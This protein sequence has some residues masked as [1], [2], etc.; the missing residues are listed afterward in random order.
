M[1]SRNANKSFA[2]KGSLKI[3]VQE[4]NSNTELGK[5][6][7]SLCWAEGKVVCEEVLWIW[8]YKKQLAHN[9]FTFFFNNTHRA[10]TPCGFLNRW[11][12]R[13]SFVIFF[14]SYFELN[15]SQHPQTRWLWWSYGSAMS[16]N[17][18]LGGAAPL[19]QAQESSLLLMQAKCWAC[20]P[21]TV[22]SITQS[23]HRHS[24]G[25]LMA[26]GTDVQRVIWR[27][28]TNRKNWDSQRKKWNQSLLAATDGTVPCNHSP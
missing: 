1:W 13:Q 23:N 7:I 27:T 9:I 16:R 28:D 18:L 4:Q 22:L 10:L 15:T 19:Y 2:W 26:H 21:L 6:L 14:L 3:L 5:G 25:P 24:A 8:G 20:C 17:S 11:K 12:N